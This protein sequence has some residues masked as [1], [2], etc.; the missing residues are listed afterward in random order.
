MKLITKL[1]DLRR[2]LSRNRKGKRVGFV[3]TM[4]ALHAGHLS[5][6]RRAAK[7]NDLVVLSIFVNPLQFGPQEDFSVY[8]RDLKK[9]MRL[10]KGCVQIVFAP[11][12]RDF[13]P[14]DFCTFV[15]VRGLSGEFCGRSRPGHFTGVATVVAKLFNA[16][17]PDTAYFGQK[18]AQQAVV[19]QKMVK[20][21][22]MPVRVQVMPTVREKDGLA[23]SSRNAYLS[24]QERRDALVLYQS[25]KSAQRMVFSGLRETQ[26]ILGALEDFIAHTSGARIDYMSIVDK[27]TLQPLKVIEKEGLLLLAVF[28]GKTR[29]IDNAVLKIARSR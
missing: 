2:E 15:E 19:I 20:D 10:V 21:L 18:D 26:K 29:L 27:K 6:A 11:Q 14:F 23:M 25:L 16:I 7:D 9:D 5:L 12:A 1:P 13:Y 17:Q 22:D 24:L 3:P 8:P 4:G 28:I